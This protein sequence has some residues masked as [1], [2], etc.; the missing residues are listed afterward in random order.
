[1]PERSKIVVVEL[2]P[3]LLAW[4]RGPLA[5]LAGRPLDDARVRLEVGD[6]A[7]RIAEARRAYDAILL[8]VDNGPSA[9]VRAEN[10]RLYGA[11]GVAACREA[12]REGG[13]LAVWSAGADAGYRARLNRAGFEVEERRV[14]ERERG[15]KRHV[16]YLARL[17]RRPRPASRA[18]GK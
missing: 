16:V 10:D 17:A 3:A 12:L 9:L 4:N 14:A 2:V 11:P 8:D 7:R 15:G 13:V 1:M 18:R 5:P 6:V